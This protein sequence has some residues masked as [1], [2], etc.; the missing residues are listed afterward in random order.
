MKNDELKTLYEKYPWAWLPQHRHYHSRR[1]W[2]TTIDPPFNDHGRWRLKPKLPA[3]LLKP[4]E[5]MM[6]RAVLLG[7]GKDII[8]PSGVQKIIGWYEAAGGTWINPGH[9]LTI[10][11]QGAYREAHV[12]IDIND[13]NADEIIALNRAAENA[14]H[15]PFEDLRDSGGLAETQEFS[16]AMVTLRLRD[17]QELLHAADGAC[18]DLEAN[19]CHA[20]KRW[21][22]RSTG[23]I[24]KWI[25]VMEENSES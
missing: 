20:G 23:R 13:T 16:E 24:R 2:T 15:D 3:D 11:P 5:D 25:G 6:N 9:Q 18:L 8:M 22:E 21:L 19:H 1:D 7:K 10:T 4:T 14:E 12:C 17:L